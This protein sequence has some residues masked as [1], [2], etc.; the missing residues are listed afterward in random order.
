M[1]SP[2]M[3]SSPAGGGLRSSLRCRCPAA[4]LPAAD[5]RGTPRRIP[6]PTE[7]DRL[8]RRYR[9]ALRKLVN[10]TRRHRAIPKL[11]AT[12]STQRHRLAQRRVVR[13]H[14]RG[15]H[16]GQAHR[17]P[18]TRHSTPDLK[19]PP[20][21]I[22]S[23]PTAAYAPVSSPSALTAACTTSASVNDAPAPQSPC[24]SMTSTSSTPPA[25]TN[26]AAS[27]A[28]T[29]PKTETGVN[30]VSGHLS[31]MSVSVRHDDTMLGK[32]QHWPRRAAM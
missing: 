31:T 32:N 2:R 17:T 10:V 30:H 8:V 21:A 9:R 23:P 11:V 24:S 13:W 5:A 29:A 4:S 6:G 14:T 15:V 19:P 27:N 28:E 25:T 1:S 12:L 18:R 7:I 3:P 20:A 16:R 26:H 22:A